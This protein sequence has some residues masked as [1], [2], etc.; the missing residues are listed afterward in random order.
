MIKVQMEI[1]FLQHDYENEIDNV[2]YVLIVDEYYYDDEKITFKN[3]L[4]EI[5]LQEMNSL[6]ILIRNKKQD[7]FGILL[8]CCQENLDQLIKDSLYFHFDFSYKENDLIIYNYEEPLEEIHCDQIYSDLDQ[9]FK[10]KDLIYKYLNDECDGKYWFNL[11]SFEKKCWLDIALLLTRSEKKD[12]K[13]IKEI[14]LDGYYIKSELDLYCYIGEEVCGVL[15]YMGASF[16]ALRDCLDGSF[17]PIQFPLKIVW[18]NFE[19]SK[20]NFIGQYYE[21]EE[22]ADFISQYAVLELH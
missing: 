11:N 7:N 18:K 20:Q 5:I 12:C 21:I 6:R 17:R 9:F 14:N 8:T 10:R 22:L 15:G 4:S 2:I 1:E 16:S 19:Y 13:K 3:C